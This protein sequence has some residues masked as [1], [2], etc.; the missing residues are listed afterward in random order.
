MAPNQ[1]PLRRLDELGFVGR[2]RSRHRPRNDERLYN[3]P[4]P[5][6]QTAD[7][8][9]A[10]PYITSYSRTYSEL[11]FEQSKMWEPGTLC[12]TI[13]GANTA[14]TAILRIEACFPDS[15]V[16]FIPDKDKA[17]LHFVK[18]SLDMMKDRFLAVSR[19]ATQ[20]NLSLDKLLS[21]RIAAP[22]PDEQRRIGAVLS[23]YD[24]LIENNARRI[25]ILEEMAQIIYLEWFV[26]SRFPGHEQ[27]RMVESRIGNFPQGWSVCRL[28][29]VA[30]L[31]SRGISPCYD[32]N[33]DSLVINQKCVRNG[34]VNLS[35][36]RRQSKKIP[37][38]KFVR[39]GDVLLN[40]TGVGT[41]GRVAQ[42]LEPIANCT[43][44]SHVSIVRPKSNPEF[45]GK[46]LLQLENHF[47]H[48]GVGST[49]QTE[50]SR[51]GISNTEIVI[52]PSELQGKFCQVIRPLNQ[53]LVCCS[54]QITNLR[55]TRDLLLPK[56]IS[57]D[58]SVESFE[59]EA[60]A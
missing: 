43:V 26:N 48:L 34:K 37:E 24:D 39:A 23:A 46:A 56:L 21:F 3:G 7:I 33:A 47:A 8:M 54:K 28:G 29:E 6:I 15:V 10:D 27:V 52:P 53:M 55:A 19:G 38:E 1:W 13:A 51:E 57:G 32:E 60:V 4:Y 42:V 45:L 31:I 14:K 17:D 40:A 20:D 30:S 41:L 16:G 49:G 36:A 12:M 44:D 9:A 35:L 5:F 50:L 58:I 18:Y 59:S 22:G 25:R 2:G 11:G